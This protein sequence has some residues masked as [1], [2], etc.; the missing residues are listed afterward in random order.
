MDWCWGRASHAGSSFSVW[1]LEGEIF[2]DA[3]EVVR[4]LVV[5]DALV[6]VSTDLNGVVLVR[7]CAVT[8]GGPP[9][10][11]AGFRGESNQFSE[12]QLAP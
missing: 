11:E 7:S 4:G 6:Q 2:N 8:V 12:K 9:T 1:I 10:I 5:S 3:G